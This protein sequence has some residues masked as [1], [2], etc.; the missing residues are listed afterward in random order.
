LL[1]LLL[2]AEPEQTRRA[3]IRVRKLRMLLSLLAIPALTFL[4][5]DDIRL[6][7]QYYPMV[8]PPFPAWVYV[9]CLAWLVF[10]VLRE[11]NALVKARKV[12]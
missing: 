12:D 8:I 5:V 9:A 2:Q 1:R 4:Y 3:I 7:L 6:Y 10:D 11:Y